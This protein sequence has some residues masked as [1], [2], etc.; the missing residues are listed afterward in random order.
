LDTG[1]IL[2]ATT[3]FAAVLGFLLL[4]ANSIRLRFSRGILI[5]MLNRMEK[6]VKQT[7]DELAQT[8]CKVEEYRM[9]VGLI[10]TTRPLSRPWAIA[11]ALSPDINQQ[12]PQTKLSR[13]FEKLVG[14]I[15]RDKYSE[16]SNMRE[17]AQEPITLRDVLGNP[18]TLELLKDCSAEN[19]ESENVMF[20]L[21]MHYFAA[22]PDADLR[23]EQIQR[24]FEMYIERDAPNQ[25]NVSVQVRNAIAMQIQNR[26]LTPT[27]FDQAEQEVMTLVQ[28]N[29]W[30]RFLQTP[31]FPLACQ[32]LASPPLSSSSARRAADG[33]RSPLT[34]V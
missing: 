8:Q 5:Q 28:T 19:R 9:M 20:L 32:L 6:V 23:S 1:T 34:S 11:L 24:I 15:S 3:A 33:K 27:I 25:I 2:I 21:D 29:T 17:P 31:A 4:V 10:N 16:M 7:K 18:I 12:L 14:G 13:P 30:P 22:I 26:Q